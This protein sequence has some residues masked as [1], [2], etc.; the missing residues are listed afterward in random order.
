MTIQL[1]KQDLN[2]A[3]CRCKNDEHT[4][5]GDFN[6]KKRMKLYSKAVILSLKNYENILK[7][8]LFYIDQHYEALFILN[9]SS[10]AINGSTD[11]SNSDISTC[12]PV[13]TSAEF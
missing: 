6:Q 12:T 7:F 4:P 2:W 1:L 3:I 8:R 13:L 11:N 9:Q 5:N 10:R